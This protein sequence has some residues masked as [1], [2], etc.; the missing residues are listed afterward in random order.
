MTSLPRL[1]ARLC[2]VTLM[3]WVLIAGMGI[4]ILQA[5]HKLD[6]I[7]DCNEGPHAEGAHQEVCLIQ[8][9]IE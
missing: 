2:L 5:V 3:G 1:A 8:L 6:D 4:L 9:K 7:V